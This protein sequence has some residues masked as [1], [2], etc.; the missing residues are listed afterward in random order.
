MSLAV[1]HT[2]AALGLNAPLVTVETHISGGLPSLSI[3]GLPETAVKE[4]KDR[5]RSAIINSEFEFPLGRITIHLGPADL[6]K[7]GGRYDLAIAISILAASNQIKADKLSNYEI[8]GELSLSGEVRPVKAVLPSAI[9]SH[10]AQ[11]IAIVPVFNAEEASLPGN[12]PVIAVKQLSELCAHL[13]EL[14]TLPFFHPQTNSDTPSAPPSQLCLSDIKGQP[15]AKRALEIAAAGGHNLLMSGPPG[16]G[17]TMLASRLTSILPEVSHHESLEIAKVQ[18]ISNPLNMNQWRQRPFRSPHHSSSA[19]ALVGGGSTPKP[20]EITQSHLGVL[21]LDELPEFDRKVLEVLREPLESGEITISRARHQITYPA[22]FQLIAAMNP[23]PC[24]KVCGPNDICYCTPAKIDKYRS[25]LSGPLLDRIDLQI[26]VN[27]IP[28]ELLVAGS[29]HQEETS[30]SVKQRVTSARNRQLAR[31]GKPNSML[32][33]K[34]IEEHCQ[35]SQADFDLMN[36]A[37]EQL[38]LS[39]RSYHRILKVARTVADLNDCDTLSTA[40]LT[41]ALSYRKL[42]FHRRQ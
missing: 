16:T 29:S 22:Q 11:K 36:Q 7:E 34:E 5:V 12:N 3:V 31:S 10:Q 13:N 21:F 25:K 23:T 38:G 6:P 8:I 37:I 28:K 39:A 41:E 2:R 24:G 40:H 35:I 27:P 14:T 30:V 1:I 15:Q 9:A 20:G 4:S 42:D 33:T 26:E 32:T 19:A 18:S 17:K